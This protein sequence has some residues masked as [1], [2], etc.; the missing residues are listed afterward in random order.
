MVKDRAFADHITHPSF[1]LH[2]QPNSVRS[3]AN[4][5]THLRNQ[6]LVITSNRPNS[7]RPVVPM[8]YVF[9]NFEESWSSKI[10]KWLDRIGQA[11]FH[12][13]PALKF[14]LYNWDILLS[15]TIAVGEECETDTAGSV[16]ADTLPA[17]VRLFASSATA[18]T[19]TLTAFHPRPETFSVTLDLFGKLS[20]LH[21]AMGII[22]DDPLG[23]FDPDRYRLAE[24]RIRKRFGSPFAT[25]CDEGVR[26]FIELYFG[27]TV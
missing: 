25:R 6:H 4:F 8:T 11:N 12:R 17:F 19:A 2:M 1:N 22:H 10:N 5:I 21:E 9:K 16:E 20:G 24:Q 27:V 26:D 3:P 23:N 14:E 7:V 15:R 18:C 13:I